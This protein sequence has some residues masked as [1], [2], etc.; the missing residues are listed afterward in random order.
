MN[1]AITNRA[2]AALEAAAAFLGVAHLM[3]QQMRL[4]H[5][6]GLYSA[7][8]TLTT[9]DAIISATAIPNCPSV[10][11]TIRAYG[12]GMHHRTATTHTGYWA[13]YGGL[14]LTRVDVARAA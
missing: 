1:I 2:V 12:P 7:R 9:S 5:C 3:P 8:A 11:I 4:T 6:V 14:E 10:L 13:L